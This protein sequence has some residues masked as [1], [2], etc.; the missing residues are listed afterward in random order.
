MIKDE[1]YRLK[2][3]AKIPRLIYGFSTRKLGDMTD[4]KNRKRFLETL[5][6]DYQ[7]IVSMNQ[8][9]GNTVAWA[10]R[11]DRGLVM[12]GTDGLITREKSVFLLARVAD[13]LSILFYD[14]VKQVVGV[15]HAGWRGLLAKIPQKMVQKMVNSGSQPSDI[16]IGI[17]PSIRSC[18]YNVSSDRAAVFSKKFKNFTP[19]I[20]IKRGGQLFLDLQRLAILQLEEQGILSKNIEDENMCTMDHQRNFYSY[21]AGDREEIAAIIGRR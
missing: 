19:K 7:D 12:E 21:R 9:H 1:V 2:T 4:N 11:K 6:I 18:C 13:C 5:Q 16:V 10:G 15:S 3:F 17:G 8:V 20:V 14:R